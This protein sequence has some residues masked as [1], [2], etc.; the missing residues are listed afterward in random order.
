MQPHVTCALVF[1]HYLWVSH[2][3]KTYIKKEKENFRISYTNRHGDYINKHYVG[4]NFQQT[5]DGLE[6]KMTFMMSN[7]G[8]HCEMTVRRKSKRND[9][10]V[11]MIH[12]VQHISGLMHE[13]RLADQE[14]NGGRHRNSDNFKGYSMRL[15]SKA[16]PKKFK[17][18]SEAKK[19]DGSTLLLNIDAEIE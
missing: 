14:I 7:G 19:D 13:Y 2:H 17:V 12:G 6:Y 4:T 1:T 5:P 3:E 15:N 10:E 8:D 11:E 18:Y 16:D 9:A